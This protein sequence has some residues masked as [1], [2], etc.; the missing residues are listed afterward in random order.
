MRRLIL[1]S[2][3]SMGF[4]VLALSPAGA[5]IVPSE[6]IESTVN[7]G[8][9]VSIALADLDGDSVLDAVVIS[10]LLTKFGL[11]Q[12]TG[13]G[14]FGPEIAQGSLYFT[15]ADCVIGDLNG[16]GRPDLAAIN[17]ACS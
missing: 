11:Y 13:S 2:A 3:S 10:K 14:S 1:G 15:P 8:S 16:D 7:E 9:P 5:G 4:L 6:A 17:S 12:G